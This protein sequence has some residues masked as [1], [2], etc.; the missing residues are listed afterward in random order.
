[1][2]IATVKVV[3]A[4]LR[5]LNEKLVWKRVHGTTSALFSVQPVVGEASVSNASS[6]EERAR[7]RSKVGPQGSS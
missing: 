5:S 3:E 2:T 4:S 1:M 6:S 7:S